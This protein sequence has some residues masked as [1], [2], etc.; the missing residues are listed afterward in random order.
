MAYQVLFS[1]QAQAD[2][3]DLYA[4]LAD[5]LG[6]ATAD[7]YTARLDRLCALVQPVSRARAPSTIHIRPGLR[8]TGFE[9]RVSIAF[10]VRGEA[11]GRGH[12]A[13]ALRGRSL[14]LPPE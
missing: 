3:D 13:P 12:P 4:Y 7:A 6:E 10:T 11:E 9:R 5:Q 14:E 8:I 2:F 1:A